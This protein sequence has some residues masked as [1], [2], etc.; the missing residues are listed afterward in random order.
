MAFQPLIY[1]I[2]N[3]MFLMYAFFNSFPILLQYDNIVE[4]V[5]A[6]IARRT[7]RSNQSFGNYVSYP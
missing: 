3:K 5:F 2:N 6:F 4:I 1:R 7:V